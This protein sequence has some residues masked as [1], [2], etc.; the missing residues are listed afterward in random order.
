MAFSSQL[1]LTALGLFASFNK[2]KL[3][4]VQSINQSIKQ[5]IN[6][7]LLVCLSVTA[8]ARSTIAVSV[9]QWD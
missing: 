7:S 4:T 2:S 9:I 5:S 3:I 1:S 8:S 6:Q